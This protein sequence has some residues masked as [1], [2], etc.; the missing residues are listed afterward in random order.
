M[1]LRFLAPGRFR[2]CAI[3]VLGLLLF[4]GLY[5]LCSLYLLVFK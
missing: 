1:D 3:I 5:L 4:I 2:V